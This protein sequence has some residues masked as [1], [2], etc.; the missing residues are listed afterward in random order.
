MDVEH[1]NSARATP[2]LE[3]PRD[4]VVDS[5]HE[6]LLCLL[7]PIDDRLGRVCGEA[8]LQYHKLVQVVP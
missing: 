8:R 6:G 7:E 3:F 1:Y 4:R 5:L 2:V